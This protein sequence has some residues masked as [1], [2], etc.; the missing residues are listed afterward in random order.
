MARLIWN[1][2][3]PNG[4]GL[5]VHVYVTRRYRLRLVIATSL[6]RLAAWIGKLGYEEHEQDDQL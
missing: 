6:M 3:K 5:T 4:P 2:P 1:G